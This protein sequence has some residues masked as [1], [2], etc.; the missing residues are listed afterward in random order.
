MSTPI[1]PPDDLYACEVHDSAD[2][3]VGGKVEIVWVD[4]ESG[5]PEF[6]GVNTNWLLKGKVHPI[7]LV[8]AEYGDNVI[9]VPYDEDQIKRSPDIGTDL[10]MTDAL[11][12][13]IYEY[14]GI[15]R[16]AGFG[17]TSRPTG[18]GLDDNSIVLP[19]TENPITGS[20][21]TLA[22]LNED[23]ATT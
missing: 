14:Y 17:P 22:D 2:N 9:R 1:T 23:E 21:E 12:G 18:S 19:G 5:Q 16:P 15:D 6:V 11:E 4:E 7:P 8:S 13:Q 10:E 20:A 3:K